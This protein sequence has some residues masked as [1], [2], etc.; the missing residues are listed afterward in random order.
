MNNNL[1]K[2][3]VISVDCVHNNPIDIMSGGPLYLGFDFYV[4]EK[5]KIDMQNLIISALEEY[6]IPLVKM[7]SSSLIEVPLNKVWN[8]ERIILEIEKDATYLCEQEMKNRN[9]SKNYFKGMIK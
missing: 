5:E 3:S 4:Y 9:Q 8:K 6:H 1:V 7:N 2:C